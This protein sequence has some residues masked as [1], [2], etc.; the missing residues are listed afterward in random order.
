[1][2][3]RLLAAALFLTASSAVL[4]PSSWAGQAVVDWDEPYVNVR[5]AP[6]TDATKVGRL[7]RGAEGEVLE[8]QGEWVRLRY[9]AGEGWVVDRSLRRLPDPVQSPSDPVATPA[10]APQEPAVTAATADPSGG[11]E[12]AAAAPPSAPAAPEP[13]PA[14]AKP[15]ALPR[16]G[17]L[18]GLDQTQVPP[19]EP[20]AGLVSMLAGLLLVLALLA[21]VVW[22]VRRFAGHRFP[23]GRRGNAI[24]VLATRAL[25]PR[26][27]LLL[28]EAGGLVWLLAQGPDGVRLIAEIQDEAALR[29]LNEQYGFQDTP[30]ESQLRKQLD[31]EEDA[32]GPT[33][34]REPSPEERLAALRRR[35]KTGEP[36]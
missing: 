14:P 16:E 8:E 2:P 31:L 5:A 35:P 24:R 3:A 19:I 9:P 20:G 36:S 25:G 32:A 22:L 26:Q 21:G 15:P 30:F 10:P 33:P 17:Y 12:P 28:A 13:E 7:A 34:D 6:G 4:Q 27:G 18:S 23:R 1:V 29:R 11:V